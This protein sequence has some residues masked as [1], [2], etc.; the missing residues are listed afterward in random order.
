MTTVIG[1]YL[2]EGCVLGMPYAAAGNIPVPSAGFT[3]L[4][5][6]LEVLNFPVNKL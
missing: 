1:M 4:L 5:T 2:P 3:V 6:L